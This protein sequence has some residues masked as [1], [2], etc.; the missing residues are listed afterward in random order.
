[1]SIFS[2]LASITLKGFNLD[3]CLLPMFIAGQ[4]KIIASLMPLEEFPTHA[5]FFVFPIY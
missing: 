3:F 2:D 5:P 1:M 4:L